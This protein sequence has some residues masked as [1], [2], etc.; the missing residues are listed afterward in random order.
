MASD[1]INSGE[2]WDFLLICECLKL[3]YEFLVFP[4]Q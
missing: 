3:L 1:Y 2:E 4:L